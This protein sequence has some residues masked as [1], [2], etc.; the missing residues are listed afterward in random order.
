MARGVF[1]FG[2][3]KRAVEAEVAGGRGRYGIVIPHVSCLRPRRQSSSW[4]GN[5]R[6]VLHGHAAIEH[7]AAGEE[8]CEDKQCD[9]QAIQQGHWNPRNE[10][11]S[12]RFFF[13][14]RNVSYSPVC[15]EYCSE[16][17]E[18]SPNGQDEHTHRDER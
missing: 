17:E 4:S 2:A 13:T 7:S 16:R 5:T 15:R 12:H 14:H 3:R 10:G 6:M 18:R 1:L 9:V 8:R 11:L